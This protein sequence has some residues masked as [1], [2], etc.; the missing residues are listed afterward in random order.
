MSCGL[1][2]AFRRVNGP[3]AAASEG[4]AE[5]SL[6]RPPQA[7][8]CRTG[9][10]LHAPLARR[11]NRGASLTRRTPPGRVQPPGGSVA[12][13]A[14]G[15]VGGLHRGIAFRRM[16]PRLARP[17]AR[18]LGAAERRG[19]V[20]TRRGQ[21]DHRPPH[22]HPG[23]VVALEV[24][25]LSRQGRAEAGGEAEFGVVGDG[26][27]PVVVLHPDH[28]GDRAENLLAADAPV[29]RRP[30][31]KRGRKKD[32]LGPLPRPFPRRRARRPCPCRSRPT[33]RPAPVGPHRR[34]ARS[35]RPFKRVA[36]AERLHPRARPPDADEGPVATPA[37]FPPEFGPG[38]LARLPKAS[39]RVI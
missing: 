29:V 28:A 23:R 2:L 15:G 17:E 21:V 16:T 9:R 5:V 18:P 10:W 7:R 20:D 14:C 37:L 32:A 24:G 13:S 3:R 4:F 27:R 6:R 34:P 35:G 36:D 33:S 38:L 25:G 26:E 12:G 1:D 11:R 22:R 31:E 19:E 8:H 30:A 39:R